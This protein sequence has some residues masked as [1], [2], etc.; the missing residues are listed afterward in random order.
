MR[1]AET[2]LLEKFE[3]MYGAPTKGKETFEVDEIEK[4][5]KVFDEVAE[6]YM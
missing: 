5:I 4:A 2:E 3:K 6:K 1:A